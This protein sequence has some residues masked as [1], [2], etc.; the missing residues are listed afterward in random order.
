MPTWNFAESVPEERLRALAASPKFDSIIAQIERE[1]K[2]LCCHFQ[3]CDDKQE[4]KRVV[5]CASVSR[6]LF[7]LF[8]NS[9]DG[10]RGSYYHSPGRGVDVN[11]RLIRSITPA[12]KVWLAE[13]GLHLCDE[14]TGEWSPSTDGAAEILNGRWELADSPNA[15]WGRKAPLLTKIRIL[16]AFINERRDEFIPARKRHRARDIHESGWS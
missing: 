1:L 3:K 14:C 12:A 9:Q 11:S 16:G 6:E 15:R 2:I 5:F 7:D 8:F 10:Y 4:F 13:T